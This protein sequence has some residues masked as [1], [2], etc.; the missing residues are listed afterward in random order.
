MILFPKCK[1]SN[2][3]YLAGVNETAEHYKEECPVSSC[4][5]GTEETAFHLRDVQGSRQ[6]GIAGSDLAGRAEAVSNCICLCTGQECLL[7]HFDCNVL[8]EPHQETWSRK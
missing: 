3:A 1:H 7:P 5:L 8:K 2:P 6:A 4:H